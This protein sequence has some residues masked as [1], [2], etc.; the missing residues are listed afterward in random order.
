MDE[1]EEGGGPGRQGKTREPCL[2]ETR[3]R[4]G[5]RPKEAMHICGVLKCNGTMKC[6]GRGEFLHSG[7]GREEA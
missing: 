1:E 5:M 7:G 6:G 4:G 3:M 2:A